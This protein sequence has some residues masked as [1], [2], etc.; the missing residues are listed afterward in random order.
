M[1]SPVNHPTTTA[2]QREEPKTQSP[3]TPK[4]VNVEQKA[5]EPWGSDPFLRKK[6]DKRPTGD[7][8]K[9]LK[10]QLSGIL[11]N[12]TSP[13]AIINNERVR[14]GDGVGG[15]RVVSIQKTNVTLEHNGKKMTLTVSKG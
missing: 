15:A 13:V 1:T 7:T 14:R 5:K 6:V 4:L 2:V 10:W 8:R 9:S 11:Y 12:S 3:A